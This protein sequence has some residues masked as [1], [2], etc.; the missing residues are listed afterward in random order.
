MAN[1]GSHDVQIIIEGRSV[2]LKLDTKALK[3]LETQLQGGPRQFITVHDINGDLHSFTTGCITA[4][5]TPKDHDLCHASSDMLIDLFK[6]GVITETELRT[7]FGWGSKAASVTANVS[8]SLMGQLNNQ[9]KQ[10][11]FMS[12]NPTPSMPIPSM[13]AGTP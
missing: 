9:L 12:P 11:K 1:S 13:P 2:V 5:T 3:D 6:N 7:H 10:I 4:L 8:S